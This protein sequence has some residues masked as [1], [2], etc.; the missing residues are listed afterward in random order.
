MRIL[1]LVAAMLVAFFIISDASAQCRGPNCPI[2]QARTLDAQP[3]SHSLVIRVAVAPVRA[4]VAVKPVRRAVAW[5]P[6]QRIRARL[7][8]R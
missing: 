8:G 6:L 1:I 5:R 2:I 7:R 4:V 3:L